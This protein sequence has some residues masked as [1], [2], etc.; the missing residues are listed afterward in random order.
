MTVHEVKLADRFYDAVWNEVKTCE[1]RKNDR[2]YKVGDTLVMKR[3]Y[4]E[5]KTYGTY[6]EDMSPDSYP[7]KERIIATIT[8]ILTHDD[9]PEGINEGYV[10]ISFEIRTEDERRV[11]Y[12]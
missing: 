7:V 2:D 3:Y 5:T 4:P 8:H 6:R 1:V 10:V 9:F 11:M 12:R